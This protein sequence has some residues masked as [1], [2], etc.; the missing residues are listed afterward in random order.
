MAAIGIIL[1]VL[2]GLITLVWLGRH[3]AINRAG[4]DANLTTEHPGPPADAPRVSVLIAAK[5]EEHNIE[6]CVN[7]MLAQDYG[8]LEVIVGNDRSTDRT[9][10][11][12]QE[13]A[14]GDPR[15]RLLTVTE[16]PAGWCGK[17][18][19]VWQGFA[20]A[21]G[22]WLC[23]VDADC[24]QTSTRTLSVAVQHAVDHDIDLLSVLPNLEMQGF[25]ENVVQPVCG[26]IMV[27]WYRP[28]KVNS[29]DSPQAYA[30]GA[31]M[32]C[33]RSAYES[34]GGHEA[35]KDHLMDDLGIAHR[36]KQTGLRLKVV[37]NDGLYSVRMYTSFRQIVNG[38]CRIFFG[39]F[40]S[41]RRLR[42]SMAVLGVMGL[43]PYATAA[44]A[45]PL[46]AVTGAGAWLA[47]AMASSAAAATQM[48]VIARFYKLVKAR[49]CLCWTYPL[50]SVI[51]MTALLKALLKH[52]RGGTIVWRGTAYDSAGDS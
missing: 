1:T 32:L 25:W 15:L 33:R 41:K 34:I 49:P 45:W 37:Q 52:R 27:F 38:W 36:I 18:N 12:L 30:N 4:A 24:R 47:A 11:I 42:I 13:I 31:F 7:T 50:G 29:P 26:G 35:V 19:A 20:T 40:S 22:E 9:G 48:S 43:V 16:L 14:A 23:F 6:G 39:T 2:C 51:A 10:E 5:D 8:N 3:L 21:T 28:E 17:N 46:W 44:L